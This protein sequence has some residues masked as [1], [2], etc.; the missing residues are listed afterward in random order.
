[1]PTAGDKPAGTNLVKSEKRYEMRGCPNKGAYW[2]SLSKIVDGDLEKLRALA[3]L[4][5]H[6]D[7]RGTL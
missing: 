5:E 2:D 3:G 6:K 1:M 7:K 4:E